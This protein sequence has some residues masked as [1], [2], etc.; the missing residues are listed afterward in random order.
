[1]PN[2][3]TIFREH[4]GKKFNSSMYIMWELP[5]NKTNFLFENSRDF[6][7]TTHGGPQESI[8]IIDNIILYLPRLQ[9]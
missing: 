4:C 2:S 6:N 5:T 7:Q 1:M 8:V 3:P 9:A